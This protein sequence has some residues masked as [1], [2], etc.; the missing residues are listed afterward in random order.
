MMTLTN[1]EKT[2]IA[3]AAIAMAALAGWQIAL[4]P[5]L[6]RIR[7]LERVC[8]QKTQSLHKLQAIAGDCAEL[9][10]EIARLRASLATEAAGRG[11][12]GTVEML[13]DE[14]GLRGNVTSMKP[15]PS[16]PNPILTEHA[17]DVR[18]EGISLQQAVELLSRI[19]RASDP[20]AVTAFDL[21][22]SA[23][24]APLLDANIRIAAFSTG[25]AVAMK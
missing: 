19:E 13:V 15:A 1:R 3:A 4:K 25:P 21:R 8:T 23:R 12:M 18:L 17:V 2:S 20:L 10:S 22:H 16:A 9:T 5:A 11:L 6:E 7:T 24:H 14:S